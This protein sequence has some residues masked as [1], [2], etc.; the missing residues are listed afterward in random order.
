M[1][2]W[3]GDVEHFFKPYGLDLLDDIPYRTIDERTH[4]WITGHQR[5][6]CRGGHRHGLIRLSTN[7]ERIQAKSANSRRGGGDRPGLPGQRV[8]VTLTPRLRD[9]QW[10]HLFLEHALLRRAR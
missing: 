5:N 6:S 3:Y 2:R 7:V 8:E 1:H 4:M 10:K 9:D